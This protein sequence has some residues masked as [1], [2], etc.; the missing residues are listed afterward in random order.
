MVYRLQLEDG[1][2]MNRL[3]VFAMAA[4]GAVVSDGSLYASIEMLMVKIFS[5]E[6]AHAIAT[7]LLVVM[8][9]FVGALIA[10][11][12]RSDESW[13]KS[14]FSPWTYFLIVFF[15]SLLVTDGITYLLAAYLK[16]KIDG[17][18]VNMLVALVIAA[19]GDRWGGLFNF[20]LTQIKK[21]FEKKGE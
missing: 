6:V 12:T 18:G 3:E 8:A 11:S 14:K 20:A 21:K 19:I 5:A 16:I 15:A 4:A 13:S 1:H 2:Y 17:S 7:L 9:S 10:V